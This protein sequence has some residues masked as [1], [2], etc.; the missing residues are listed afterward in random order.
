MIRKEIHDGSIYHKSYLY[1]VLFNFC[2]GI[3]T[4]SL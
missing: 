2:D 4:D 3:G 1:L